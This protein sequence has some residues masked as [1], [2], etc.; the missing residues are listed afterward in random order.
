MFA[1]DTSPASA[2]SSASAAWKSPVFDV[3][4]VPRASAV[5]AA[6]AL[7]ATASGGQDTPGEGNVTPIDYV[8]PAGN[9]ADNSKYTYFNGSVDG[10]KRADASR[11]H[12]KKV[13]PIRDI[14]RLRFYWGSDAQGT[15]KPVFQLAEDNKLSVWKVKKY[16]YSALLDLFKKKLALKLFVR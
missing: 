16:D 7:V 2:A 1:A 11:V 6:A 9:P 15:P 10:I 3:A 12:S 4:A 14:Q 8:L 13:V 5:R